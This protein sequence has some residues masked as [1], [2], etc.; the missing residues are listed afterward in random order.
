MSEN[1]NLKLVE[2]GTISYDAEQE[3]LERDILRMECNLRGGELNF[4]V[5]L[6]FSCLW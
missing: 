4:T 5:F 6:N 3:F 2:W 1:D